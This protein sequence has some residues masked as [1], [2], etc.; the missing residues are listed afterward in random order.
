[1]KHSASQP[2]VAS[3]RARGSLLDRGLARLLR[4]PPGGLPL[5]KRLLLSALLGLTMGT[6]FDALHVWNDV[7]SYR[8]TPRLPLL[9]VAWY[10]P[11]EFALAGLIVGTLRPELD[12]ELDRQPAPLSRAAVAWGIAMFSLAWWGSG[13][14]A[15]QGV[16][17]P[18][19]ANVLTLLGVGVWAALDGTRQGAIAAGITAVLG[20]LVEAAI[21]AHGTYSYTS[22]DVLGVVPQWLPSLYVTA[23]VAI[24]NLGR[25]MKYSWSPPPERFVLES[26]PVQIGKRAA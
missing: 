8:N 20:V 23:C 24:G 21:V 16:P 11:F 3:E 14:L 26:G 19:I 2:G 22:P 12:E 18:A 10:V 1:M 7:A 17:P 5:Y 4:R 15:K 9:D 6:L 25:Y 13:A